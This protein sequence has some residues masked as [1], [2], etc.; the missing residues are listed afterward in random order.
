VRNNGNFGSGGLVTGTNAY[1]NNDIIG[2]TIGLIIRGASGQTSS[3]QQWQN[4]SGG[5]VATMSAA[6]DLAVYG[7]GITSGDHRIG[8]ATYLNAALNVQARAATEIGT[9]VRGAASQSANLQEW[10]S[11]AGSILARVESTGAAMFGNGNMSVNSVGSIFANTVN[12]NIGRI[13]MSEANSGGQLTVTRQTAAATNP[14][15]NIG[16]LYFRDGTN[17]GTLKLVVR[18]GAAGAETTILDNIPT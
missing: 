14:G 18:A 1:I 15:A 9:V 2:N 6:G 12:T 10:Q 8:T 4:N 11:S 7:N 5:L 3:L 16:R 17:A 13:G